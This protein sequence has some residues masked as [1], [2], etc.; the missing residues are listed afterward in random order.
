MHPLVRDL[1]KRFLLVGKDYP[2]GINIIK[3]KTK[4]EFNKNK[5]LNNEIDIKK[6][7]GR[8]R[9]MI[10]E[11]IGIIQLKKYRTIKSK[12][13]NNNNENNNNENSH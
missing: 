7:V 2:G 5:N 8:G 11:L 13:N 10:R 9:Y 6:A 1:Y 4:E 12:Y 3:N